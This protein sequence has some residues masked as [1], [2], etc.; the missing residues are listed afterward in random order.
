MT[1]V[2]DDVVLALEVEVLRVG[3]LPPVPP[4]VRLAALLS[5]FDRRR[6]IADHRVEP[7][8]DPLLLVLG[9]AGDRDPHPPVQVAGDR[10]RPDLVE[11]PEREVLDVRAPV[12]V[13]RDPAAQAVGELRQVEEEVLRLPELGDGAVD[14]RPGLDQI[15]R[16]ELVAAVVALVA[17]RLRIPADRARS[18][19]VAVRQRVPGRRRERDE[20]LA[21]DDRA[22]LVQRPEQVLHD[23]L[24]IE[25]RRP[26]EQV[27]GETQAPEI[28]AERVVVVV[29]DL[30]VRLPFSVGDHHHGRAVLVGPAHHQDV[31]P[32][33]PV[34]AR[35][36]IR[37]DAEPRHVAKVTVP[38]R[39]RP[40][41]R[42]EYLPAPGCHPE[43]SYERRS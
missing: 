34:I 27:V 38:R 24:V 28:L 15:G 33:Q 37:G 25:R 31:V 19:D 8:V 4:G 10:P 29:G 21:L 20:H 7:D 42:H 22:V 13:G 39:I 35:E 18:L 9:V 17:A 40:G 41:R 23:A 5:P 16:V 30:N 11:Q 32:A 12:V 6:E 3:V 43:Q 2:E 1:R 36:H 14:P 26:R